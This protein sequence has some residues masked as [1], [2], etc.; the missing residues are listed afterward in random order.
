MRNIKYTTIRINVST[1][2][3]LDGSTL[4]TG[5]PATGV[6]DPVTGVVSYDV[7]GPVGVFD[8][9]EII[10][11]YT[12]PLVMQGLT[13]ENST[14]PHESGSIVEL[15]SPPT[16]DNPAA[17][18]RALAFSLAGKS[19]LLTDTNYVVPVDHRIALN[20][21]ADDNG[22]P[23]PHVIQFSIAR[24][25]DELLN[26]LL[27]VEANSV[28]PPSQWLNPVRVA[29]TEDVDLTTLA[30][31]S[32]VDSQTLAEG[33]RVL[34]RVQTDPTENGVYTMQ[35]AAPGVR[36]SDMSSDSEVRSGLTVFVTEGS[37]L[38]TT[39]WTLDRAN[40]ILI[41]STPLTFTQTGGI[42]QGRRLWISH[43]WTVNTQQSVD[44]IPFDGTFVAGGSIT[45]DPIR[46]FF[47]ERMRLIS[48]VAWCLGTTPPDSVSVG[49]HVNNDV[50]PEMSVVVDMDGVDVR[51]LFDFT[52]SG[53]DNLTNVNQFTAIGF[54]T[55]TDPVGEMRAI[56]YWE[57]VV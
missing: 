18:H 39:M 16:L 23:G 5:T 47:P 31:G 4:F 25:T 34:L 42:G 3:P 54:T 22:T 44:Y 24:V 56:S 8:L 51:F 13:V 33:D 14:N 41:G 1:D 38:K 9:A 6:I 26:G 2:A 57:P 11:I 49:L 55:D 43:K 45:F 50:T 36:S 21:V 7:V 53:D 35:A 27:A 15:E 20:T 17:R 28:R 52:Q 40:P 19:G 46:A 29:S 12:V 30:A 48:V 37:T 32:S 10:G